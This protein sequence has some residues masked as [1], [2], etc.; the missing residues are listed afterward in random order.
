VFPQKAKRRMQVLMQK[1]QSARNF[2]LNSSTTGA[3]NNQ[4]REY[5]SE[6]I[7]KE[8]ESLVALTISYIVDIGIRRWRRRR[9]GSLVS[10]SHLTSAQPGVY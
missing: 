5:L 8:G 4:D 2:T 10:R 1:E 9:R 6:I 7:K 3:F